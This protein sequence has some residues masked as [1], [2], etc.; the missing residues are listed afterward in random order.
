M[1]VMS[2]EKYSNMIEELE[3]DRAMEEKFRNI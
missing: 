2:L 3:I 1:A